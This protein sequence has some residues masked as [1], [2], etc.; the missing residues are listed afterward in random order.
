[1]TQPE[2]PAGTNLQLGT[3]Q[4][5]VWRKR[6]IPFYI[7]HNM[8]LLQQKETESG[9]VTTTS[10]T[11]SCPPPLES[12]LAPESFPTA[13]LSITPTDISREKFP[14]SHSSNTNPQDDTKTASAENGGMQPRRQLQGQ[15]PRVQSQL[16][17]VAH[18]RGGGRQIPGAG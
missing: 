13:H 18:G 2:A 15:K 6:T 5:P 16:G 11:P 14:P 4:H 1:M 7:T 10:I 8:G 12:S 9:K 3:F 17:M